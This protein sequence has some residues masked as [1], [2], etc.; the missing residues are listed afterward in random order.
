MTSQGRSTMASGRII[1]AF[2][3]SYEL[4]ALN[5]FLV[6]NLKQKAASCDRLSGTF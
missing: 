4:R 6:G 3:A 2:V 5:S 1:L